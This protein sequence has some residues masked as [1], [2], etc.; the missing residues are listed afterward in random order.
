MGLF[1]RLK[2]QTPLEM[3]TLDEGL[4]VP[5]QLAAYWSHVKA[6]GLPSLVIS[7]QPGMGAPDG[8][9]FGHIPCLPQGY[10]YPKDDAGEYLFPLAQFNFAQM[11]ELPGFPRE[12]LLQFYISM[13]DNLDHFDEELTTPSVKVLYFAPD[14][15]AKPMLDFSAL[16]HLFKDASRPVK[17]P[18][19]LSF[20]LQEDYIGIGDS[21]TNQQYFDADAFAAHHPAEKAQLLEFV[22]ENLVKSGHKLG[23][24]ASFMSEDPR[25][26]EL[27][28]EGYVPLLQMRVDKEH[29][30]E[31][32]HRFFIHPKQLAARDFSRVVY[33]PDTW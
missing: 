1:N 33:H 19:L 20:T 9:K 27:S 17:V 31:G 30:D 24:Y 15:I 6:A 8:N 2:K 22:H 18:Q 7:A 28:L 23:G 16:E 14:E 10:D 29:G 3:T 13:D 26:H 4:V 21:L 25:R 32:V 12:G 5:V 11:P